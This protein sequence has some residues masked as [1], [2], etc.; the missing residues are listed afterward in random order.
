MSHTP[1]DHTPLPDDPAQLKQVLAQ[2]ANQIRHLQARIE[3]L[4]EEKRRLLSRR[5]GPS[6]EKDPS[7]QLRL[8]NEP[9]ALQDED[10]ADT[11]DTEAL[12]TVP[13]HKRRKSGRKP[14]PEHL[15]R[16]EVEHDLSDAEKVS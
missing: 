15:P 8:F 5:Y 7:P 9:E 6:S 2:Q 3:Q 16:I 13:A 10:E 12:V 11:E 1:A 14:L 4:E